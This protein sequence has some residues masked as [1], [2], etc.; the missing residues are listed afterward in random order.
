MKMVNRK[1]LGM[2][3]SAK[4]D[5]PR[6]IWRRVLDRSQRV[7]AVVRAPSPASP[8]KSR[9][10]SVRFVRRFSSNYRLWHYR[11]YS[12]SLVLSIRDSSGYLVAADGIEAWWSKQRG[13]LATAS[14]SSSTFF[15]FS[16]S[17]SSSRD[18]NWPPMLQGM[19]ACQCY[20]LGQLFFVSILK[21]GIIAQATI[22][23]V[24]RTWQVQYDSHSVN[25]QW[26]VPPLRQCCLSTTHNHCTCRP[27]FVLHEIC[28]SGC[29]R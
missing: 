17:S 15:L 5:T 6:G 27:A 12:S 7:I 11:P 4:K 3:K 28:C 18:I 1:A 24:G 21:R 23:I 9:S 20:N 10:A 26:P 13:K 2:E 14:S 19:Q 29:R 8:L 16:S 25:Q 22:E